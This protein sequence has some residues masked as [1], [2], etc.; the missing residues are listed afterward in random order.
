M[1]KDELGVALL[2]LEEETEKRMDLEKKVLSLEARNKE[3]RDVLADRFKWIQY[4]NEEVSILEE[5][6]RQCTDFKVEVNNGR[7]TT[8]IMYPA[9]Q[10]ISQL[11]KLRESRK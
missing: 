2:A 10:A 4:L 3:H 8:T 7:N 6:L 9:R 5:A 1:S 11:I